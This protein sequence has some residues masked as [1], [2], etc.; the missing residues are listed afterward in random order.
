MSLYH[1]RAVRQASLVVSEERLEWL[2]SVAVP[3]REMWVYKI[4]NTSSPLGVIIQQTMT[5]RAAFWV[6]PKAIQT[7]HIKSKPNIWNGAFATTPKGGGKGKRSKIAAAFEE[8][9]PVQH[10]VLKQLQNGTWLCQDYQKGTCSNTGPKC[11]S[12]AHLCGLSSEDTA[13]SASM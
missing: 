1:S 5:E 8:V 3:E 6:P 2:Q 13:Y 12:G 10:T 11:P 4:H 9:K 7:G